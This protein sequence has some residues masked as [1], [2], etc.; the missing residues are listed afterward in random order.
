MSD[1]IAVEIHVHLGGPENHRIDH[2]REIA[3]A[4]I[5]VRGKRRGW[6]MAGIARDGLHRV[7]IEGLTIEDVIG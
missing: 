3:F 1:D 2:R 4:V 5:V 6:H 7:K